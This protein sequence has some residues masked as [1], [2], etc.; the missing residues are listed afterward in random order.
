MSKVAAF[1]SGRRTRWVV[2]GFWLIVVAALLPFQK[3]TDVESNEASAW[4]PKNAESVSVLHRAAAL[5]PNETVPGVVVYDRG[6]QA[7][8]DADLAKVNADAAAFRSVENVTGEISPPVRSGDGQAIQLVVNLHVPQDGWA[9]LGKSVDRMIELAKHDD[10]GLSVH[11]TGAGG[12]AADSGKVFTQ[13]GSLM[14]I[15]LLIVIVILLAAY[16]SPVLVLRPLFAAGVA[17]V[18][19]QGV[20]YLLAKHA[21]L[22]VNAQSSFILTVLVFGAATDY[23]L[24]LIARYRQE[25]RR[26]ENPNAAMAEAWY[27]SA[28]AILASAAT[29]T[30][31]MLVLLFAHLG[32][33]QGLGPVC[34]VGILS[35]V[36]VMTTLLPA[37]LVRGP[38]MWTLWRKTNGRWVFWPAMPEF[39]S[40]DPTESGLWAKIGDWV[41]VR[42]R[43]VWIAATLVLVALALGIT[44]LRANGVPDRHSLTKTTQAMVGADVLDQHF[45]AGAGDPVY[46]LTR[47]DAADQVRA[48]VATVDGVIVPATPPL[49]KDG[50]AMIAATLTDSPDSAAAIATVG[51]MRD[52]V[53]R[54]PGAE[55]EVGG[56]TAVKK[57]MED[58]AAR[59]SRVLVPVILLVVF[60]ILAL[61][62]RAIVAPVLLIATVVVSFAA[63]MGISALVFNHVFHFAGADAS[64]PLM[65]FA[66]LVALGVDYNIFL[67][68]RIREETERHGARRG[69]L[70]GLSATGGVIT[71]AGLVLAGTFAALGSIPMTF[72]AELGFTVALGVL[73]DT[74]IVRSVVVTAL[75]LD[76]DRYLWWPSKLFRSGSSVTEPEPADSDEQVAPQPS[77]V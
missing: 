14:L 37:R 32:S 62:L 60:L 22:T 39:G 65:A 34:A 72:A 33:T 56:S 23:A 55:A 25:L 3:L 71:S 57:D 5:L 40:V 36:L 58:A 54:I 24:L 16:R 76:F 53:H 7:L 69:A 27:R 67:V 1:L 70:I 15:T 68:T 48:A 12:Y 29:V 61:L 74:F 45:V 26:R 50:T 77:V 18:V 59:D 19:A 51:E 13:G 17:L 38:W 75:A 64:F 43:R 4:L 30:V 73:I 28:E 41:A 49:V 35:S 10:Q 44:G 8:T 9:G 31:S 52:A 11:V 63:T 21:G 42:P 47:A 2:V 6:G 66:F 46:I 20:V